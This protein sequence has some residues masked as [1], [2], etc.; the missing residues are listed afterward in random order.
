MVGLP[1]DE[2]ALIARAR[3]GSL[4]AFNVLVLAHQDSVYTL[5][6][7]LMGDTH[8]AADATQ[9][10]FIAAYRKLTSYRGGSFRAWL[11]R[12]ATNRCYDELRK[13]QRTPQSSLDAG[14]TEDE[15]ELQFPD[16]GE[17]PEQA[18]LRRELQ[19]ALQ[20][21]IS[22]LNHDQRVVLVLSDVEGMSYEAIAEQAEVQLG[23]VKS[24][25]S[26][27][28][29]AVRDCLQ[30]VRELLPAQYRLVSDEE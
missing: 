18:A 9:E 19:R 8:S 5:A 23:T 30:A 4:E 17:T 6:Y 20:N 1:N 24:R 29:A 28:R 15:P 27:A 13:R 22:A 26:R 10:A 11:L 25:L 14:G 2:A 12:I 7:R 3:R 21:C 16:T